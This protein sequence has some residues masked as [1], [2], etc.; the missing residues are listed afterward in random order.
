MNSLF[1]WNFHVN[2]RFL[3][4]L[5]IRENT[6]VEQCKEFSARFSTKFIHIVDFFMH[7]KVVVVLHNSLFCRLE[8]KFCETVK[9]SCNKEEVKIH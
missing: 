7:S 9:Y 5:L 8:M 6:V 2:F 4:C 3:E 1:Y